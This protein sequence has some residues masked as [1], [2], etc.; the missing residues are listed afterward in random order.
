VPEEKYNFSETKGAGSS[1]IMSLVNLPNI[2]KVYGNCIL[3]FNI[4]VSCDVMLLKSL[5]VI[6]K[7]YFCNKII[8][9]STLIKF[10]TFSK[11]YVSISIYFIPKAKKL[12]DVGK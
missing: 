7:R 4:F 3:H 11:D 2:N 5:N 12:T 1:N 10:L 6:I 8:L 9:Y